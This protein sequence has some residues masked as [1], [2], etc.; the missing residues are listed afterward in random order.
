MHS[1]LIYSFCFGRFSL[2]QYNLVYGRREKNPSDIFMALFY[3]AKK[4][5]LSCALFRFIAPYRLR[6]C[7]SANSASSSPLVSSS[8]VDSRTERKERR[9][10]RGEAGRAVPS[11]KGGGQRGGNCCRKPEGKEEG[12]TQTGLGGGGSRRRGCHRQ[13]TEVQ[14]EGAPSSPS[15]HGPKRRRE[16]TEEEGIP[17]TLSL[18][19]V[20]V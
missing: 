1:Y 8:S 13:R 10:G 6:L 14:G 17:S 12:G 20:S 7:V 18:P 4:I 16:K 2:F 11:E 3:A 19:L 9:G 5:H 15:K